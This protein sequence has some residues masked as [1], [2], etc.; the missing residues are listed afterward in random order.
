MGLIEIRELLAMLLGFWTAILVVLKLPVSW[1]RWL[2]K[3]QQDAVNEQTVETL[4]TIS[5]A[6]ASLEGRMAVAELSLRV[7]IRILARLVD[8]R[9]ASPPSAAATSTTEDARSG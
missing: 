7:A 3:T 2:Y 8:E 6:I 5:K 1:R 9:P 4:E